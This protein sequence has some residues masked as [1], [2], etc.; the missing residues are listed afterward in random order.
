MAKRMKSK[1]GAPRKGLVSYPLATFLIF[2]ERKE[3]S[4]KTRTPGTTRK[5]CLRCE[6][7]PLVLLRRRKCT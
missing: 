5:S 1:V 4:M 7:S 6:Q 2:Y 3:F